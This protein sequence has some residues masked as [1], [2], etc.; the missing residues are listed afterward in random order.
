MDKSQLFVSM[1]VFI[2]LAL[3]F[4]VARIVR[5]VKK[6]ERSKTDLWLG[7]G[8]YVSVLGCGI[9]IFW[10]LQVSLSIATERTRSTERA[11]ILSQRMLMYA[12]DN[13]DRLPPVANWT[14]LI[15]PYTERGPDGPYDDSGDIRSFTEGGVIGGNAIGMNRHAGRVSFSDVADATA[16]VML[17]ERIGSGTNLSV[18]ERSEF[19]GDGRSVAFMD[20][21]AKWL[22]RASDVELVWITDPSPHDEVDDQSPGPA[23]DQ[24]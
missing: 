19:E 10:P 2:A 1:I 9:S 6:V 21:Y 7:V 22:P 24:E 4:E 14:D 8:L 11:K 23:P 15:E 16:Q 5:R 3:A 18:D 20:G 17:A 13:D 12:V